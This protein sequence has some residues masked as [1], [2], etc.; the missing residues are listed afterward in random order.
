MRI[1]TSRPVAN[2]AFDDGEHTNTIDWVAC[3]A[4]PLWFVY[5]DGA[6]EGRDLI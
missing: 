5:S 2:V 6:E 1:E 3:F 4:Y